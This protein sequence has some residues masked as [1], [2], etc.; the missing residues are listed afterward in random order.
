MHLIQQADRIEWWI[1]LGQQ[2][3][4]TSIL[5]MHPLE[6]IELLEDGDTALAE[7]ALAIIEH[8][9]FHLSNRI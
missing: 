4:L 3:D 1:S 7:A 2:F 6:P 5:I 9:G 8:D